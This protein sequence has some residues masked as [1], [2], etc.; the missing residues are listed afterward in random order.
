MVDAMALIRRRAWHDVGG[1]THIEGGWEDYDFWCKLIEAGYHGLLCPQIL[2]VYRSHA[3]SMSHCATNQSW[4]ALSRT[5]QHRH[6][7]LS[8]PLADQEPQP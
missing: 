7:W 6:P 4:R 3:Q 1:Y 8:L 2:A 5:L